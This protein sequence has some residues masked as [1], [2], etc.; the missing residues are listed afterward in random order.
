[1]PLKSVR[2]STH[3]NLLRLRCK[4]KLNLSLNLQGKKQKSCKKRNRGKIS[5][6]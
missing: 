3:P 4:A 1:M 5:R 2:I 6:L